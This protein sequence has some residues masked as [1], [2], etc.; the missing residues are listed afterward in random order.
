M[1]GWLR[2]DRLGFTLE[3]LAALVVLRE[4]DGQDLDRDAAVE[5][6]V[7]PPPDLAHSAGADRRL[8]F[9]RPEPRPGLDWHEWADSTA[10]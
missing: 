9:I 8:K 5:A 7:L 10:S 4:A 2:G 6:G 1:W 3:A